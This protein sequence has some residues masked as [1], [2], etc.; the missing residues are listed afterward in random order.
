MESGLG[1]TTIQPYSPEWW[2]LR[3]GCFTA[4]EIFKLMTE[5]RSKA[6]KD[7]GE[8]SDG[9]L[10]YILEKVHEKLTGKA[11]Q[12]IDNFATQWGVEHEPMALKWYAKLT[13][14]KL[15]SPVLCL[16]DELEGF[17]CTPDTFVNDDGLAEIKCPANGANH[18]KHCFITSDEYFKSEHPD[19][20][21][22]AVSQMNITKRIYCDFVSFDPRINSDLGMFIY[23]LKYQEESE[24]LLQKK[25]KQARQVYNQ[26]LEMFSK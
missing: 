18:L 1:I 13:G 7:A 16:H 24:K 11:K 23:R 2:E 19:Y 25:V 14:N 3:H 6:A 15:D 12:G 10:T 22:Q 21:W 5:P 4:S 9:A 17:S 26:Y 8:L 20:Y